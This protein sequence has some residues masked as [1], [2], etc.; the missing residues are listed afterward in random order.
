VLEAH[1]AEWDAWLADIEQNGRRDEAG[2]EEWFATLQGGS[3]VW[4]VRSETIN[5]DPADRDPKL[6]WAHP[7]DIMRWTGKVKRNENDP[8]Y[9]LWYEVILYKSGRMMKGW[10]KGNIVDP[11]IFP[12]PENDP[13]NEAN[14]DKQFDL[15]RPVLRHPSDK[16]IEDTI[17]ARR[18]ARQYIDV[19]EALGKTKIHHNLCG[20]FCVAALAGRDIIPFLKEWIKAYSQA[21]IRTKNILTDP[22]RLL[23]SDSGTGQPDVE[24]MLDMCGISHREYRYTPSISPIT[25]LRLKREINE[26]GAVFWGVSIFK[27]GGKLSGKSTSNTTRH[28]IVLEDVIPVGNSGWVRIY[29][30]FMN[31][32]EVY[33]YDYFIESVGQF[34][35]G[36]RVEGWKRNRPNVGVVDPIDIIV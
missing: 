27:A 36:L 25:S 5:Q 7:N 16:E 17:A 13:A 35:L 18:G 32:E 9:P 31:R 4:P 1:Q 15:S 21:D 19:K 3:D 2:I 24:F 20:E 26:G 33:N 28:W 8:K 30:P 23:N 22:V 14:A 12:T 10:F 34:G 11:Y 6:G 29:N